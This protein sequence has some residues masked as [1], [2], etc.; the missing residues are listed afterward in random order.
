MTIDGNVIVSIITAIVAIFALGLT[1]KQIKLSNKQHLFDKR[2]ENYIIA[3]G[4]LDL[5]RTNC[6]HLDLDK[7]EPILNID[8]YF[9]WLSNNT[10]LE[11]ITSVINNPLE[12][13]IH[14]KFL[15]KSENMKEVGTKINFLFSDKTSKVLSDFVF[16]YQELLFSMYQY[17]IIL[18]KMFEKNNEKRSSIE[19]MQK[20]FDEPKY[21]HNLQKKY[22]NLIEIE[23]NLKEN[24]VEEKIKKQIKLV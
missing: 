13:I 12:K 1:F 14:K 17:K 2:I 24:K 16:S 11:D 20:M 21:R 4:L 22:R 18:N 15:I 5:Y 3:I 19:V 8:L 23:K 10:Y 6:E 9:T 7:D